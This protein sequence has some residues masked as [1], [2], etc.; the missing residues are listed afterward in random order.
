MLTLI[1][2]IFLTTYATWKI[3]GLFSQVDYKVQVHEQENF[4]DMEEVFGYKDG[5]M[6]AAGL[7]AYDGNSQDITDPS[8]GRLKFVKKS[9]GWTDTER[10]EFRDVETQVC[11]Q[12]EL[13]EGGDT[14]SSHF[15]EL[16]E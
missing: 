7:T 1:T 6:V 3:I 11:N 12:K 14:A 15:Y 4:Y 8:I 16:A 10:V 2:I 13:L 9:F 5:F